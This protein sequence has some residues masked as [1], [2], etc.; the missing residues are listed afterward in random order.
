MELD[1]SGLF[2]GPSKP[3]KATT[4]TGRVDIPP[5]E[6]TPTEASKPPIKD[7]SLERDAEER[8]RVADNYK[9]QAEAIR[10]TEMLRT[11]ITKG[12]KRGEPLPVLFLQAIECAGVAT[13]D[14]VFIDQC[15][16]DLVTVYGIGLHQPEAAAVELGE[17]RERLGNLERA[18]NKEWITP[19]EKQ[20]IA[21]AIRAHRERETHLAAIVG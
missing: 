20:R 19:D 21:A 1:F 3:Q 12:I 13:G 15:K 2:G 7:L 10:K 5:Q 18:Y 17:V 9:R 8:Q 4:A 14:R 6:K 16:A 11:A